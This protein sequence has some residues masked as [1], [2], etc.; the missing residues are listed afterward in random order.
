MNKQQRE[1]QRTLKK[2]N[3]MLASLINS[4]SSDSPELHADSVL[5][6]LD[7]YTTI[8]VKLSQ[9]LLKWAELS[10]VMAKEH[11]KHIDTTDHRKEDVTQEDL[12][13]LEDYFVRKHTIES[14]NPKLALK[15]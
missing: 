4:H 11:D 12:Q 6:E 14:S 13:L 2:L 1:L 10:I 9:Q 7:S 8:Y 5:K 15:A 3:S